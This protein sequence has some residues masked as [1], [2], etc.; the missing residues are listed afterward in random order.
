VVYPWEPTSHRMVLP[1]MFPIP[2]LPGNTLELTACPDEY[3]PAS[4]IIR[5]KE[6][7]SNIT[8]TN[9]DLLSEGGNI[10]PSSALDIKI[11]KAWYQANIDSIQQSKPK[12]KYLV[13]ELL[14]N[15][16]TLIKVDEQ[17]QTNFVRI[18]LNNETSYINISEPGFEMPANAVIKDALSL[19][20][21]D[22][23][24]E[25]NKQIWLTLKVPENATPGLYKGKLQ[26]KAVDADVLEMEIVA[27]VLDFTLPTPA[28][29]YSI[30]Y[31]GQ[32]TLPPQ[33]S[34]PFTYGGKT[35]AQYRIEFDNMKKHGLSSA[36]IYQKPHHKNLKK[37]LQ[38]RA[39]TGMNGD[40]LY[41]V[42]TQTG[43]PTE[44]ADLKILEDE[45]SKWMEVAK[46]YNYKNV[47]IFGIDEGNLD[48]IRSQ[49]QA[50]EMVHK[51][52]A[53]IIAACPP[54]SVDVA[55]SLLNI[56][57]LSKTTDSAVAKKWHA[58]GA[59]V[60]SY[61]NPQVGVENPYIYRKNYGIDLW[62][63]GYDGTM[64]YAYQ[65]GMGHIWNDFD[66]DRYRDHVFAYPVTDGVI[67]TIQWEGFREAIDDVRYITKL[68]STD[69][70]DE[71]S[72][73]KWL[74][75]MQKDNYSLRQIR[76]K[77]IEEINDHK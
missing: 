16:D 20:P 64:N 9:T 51:A 15:D 71:T 72:L 45:V 27:N 65:R 56:G 28:L 6:D 18:E 40:N 57:N 74:T 3:E 46:E 50:W 60:F 70:M 48:I 75:Q 54:S 12:K 68:L 31:A 34:P 21:F 55:N 35:S 32:L 47:F 44:E 13:P 30:Y 39:E 43:N 29:E 63:A 69:F 10:I 14:L 42:G 23:K 77:V 4:F 38:I 25:T 5:A 73:K 76:Q 52:G 26:I 49:K 7:L 53:G 8:I 67:D 24:S 62:L 41:V 59:K 58:S 1:D 61:G 33:E 19:K 22:V 17:S 11:V 2:A 36:T 37:A 66:H